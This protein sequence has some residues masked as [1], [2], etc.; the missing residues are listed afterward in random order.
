MDHA[1]LINVHKDVEQADRML[2]IIAEY[3]PDSWAICYYDGPG[4]VRVPITW[5]YAD[6]QPDKIRSIIGALNY[7]VAKAHQCHCDYASFLHADMVPTDAKTFRR[8]LKRFA[9]SGKALTYNVMWADHPL[10]D[11]C[12]LHF[13]VKQVVDMGLFPAAVE[14]LSSD[15]RWVNEAQLTMSFDRSCPVWRERTYRPWTIVL[16]YTNMPGSTMDKHGHLPGGWFVFHN[17]T[18]ET[19]VIH[20]NDPW[21]WDNYD[22]IARRG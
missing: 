8:F 15:P 16:P 4:D 3:Y 22:T 6:Y 5:H 21:F 7:L 10:I 13:D 9:A 1:F 18:P 19:S 14:P 12:N 11:F 2:D 17:Y 20:T